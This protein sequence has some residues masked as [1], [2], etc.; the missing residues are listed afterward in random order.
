[1]L[2]N[3][4]TQGDHDNAPSNNVATPV[5][6][7]VVTMAQYSMDRRTCKDTK[8]ANSPIL[9][10]GCCREFLNVKTN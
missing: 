5:D 8:P 2:R 10:G 3:I 9:H 4:A 7:Y 1:V 6:N